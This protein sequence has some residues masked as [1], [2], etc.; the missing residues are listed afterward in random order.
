[1][2][3]GWTE[4]NQLSQEQYQLITS[5]QPQIEATS[6]KEFKNGFHPVQIRQQVV[7]GMN[8]W[9]KIQVG[10][11]EYIHVK[12]F[13]PLPHTGAPAEIK[14]VTEGHTLEEAI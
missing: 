3:G 11:S 4:S 14:E 10:E 12:I 7:A 8:Y 5:L 6:G 1:M 9:V 2:L 13:V